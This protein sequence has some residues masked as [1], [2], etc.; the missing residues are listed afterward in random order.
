[1][2]NQNKHL[3]HKDQIQK[4]KT[5]AILNHNM[6]PSTTGA[7]WQFGANFLQI[8]DAR[9]PIVK[10]YMKEDKGNHKISQDLAI[11]ANWW[12]EGWKCTSRT[13]CIR[14]LFTHLYIPWV[15]RGISLL[16][17]IQ[18]EKWSRAVNEIDTL[19]QMLLHNRINSIGS[20]LFTTVP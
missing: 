4:H 2:I 1:M 10:F 17:Y 6:W 5:E 16:N 7:F 18:R 13:L 3:Q 20:Y 9:M 15:Y 12:C 8:I 14:G 11:Y 19:M